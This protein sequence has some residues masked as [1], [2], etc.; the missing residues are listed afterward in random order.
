MK[1]MMSKRKTVESPI[2]T[3][4]NTIFDNNGGT[5]LISD[6]QNEE[7]NYSQVVLMVF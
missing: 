4:K 1:K 5:G 6:R 3:T 2:E 7:F